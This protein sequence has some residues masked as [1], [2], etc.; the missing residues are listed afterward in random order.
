MDLGTGRTAMQCLKEWLKASQHTP[1]SKHKNT[2]WSPEDSKKLEALVARLG[3]NWKV[4][5]CACLCVCVCLN[6]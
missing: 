3:H 5:E 2:K 4:S 6:E 1:G